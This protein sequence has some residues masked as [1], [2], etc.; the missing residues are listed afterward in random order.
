MNNYQQFPDNFLIGGAIAALQCEGAYNEG[1][2]GKATYDYYTNGMS[3]VFKPDYNFIEDASKNYRNRKGIDF[4]HRYKEDIALF[5]EMGFKCL[6][7][8]IAWPRIFPNGDDELPNEEGLVFYDNVIDELLKYN[9]EPLI[10]L[11]H[12]EIPI[13]LIEKYQGWTNRYLIQLFE[14]YCRVL[15]ERYK[16]KVK[17]WI[18]FNEINGIADPGTFRPG[19][20]STFAGCKTSEDMDE[21]MN[22]LFNAAHHQLIASAKVVKMCHEIMP[23]AK[24][25]GM[26]AMQ[27]SYAYT[28]NPIDVCFNMEE[29]ERHNYY[30]GDVLV[31]GAYGNYAKRVWKQANAK[32][33]ILDGDLQILKEGIVDYLAIS[34]YS[35]NVVAKANSLEET[36]GNLFASSVNPYLERSQWGWTK[37]SLGLYIACEEL[38]NRYQIPLFIV[39]NG[40]GAIDE[41]IIDENGN[42]IIHDP[43]RIDYIKDHLLEIMHAIDNGVKIMG[44]LEW[45][46]IDMVSGGTGEM[47]KRYGFIYV[48]L[49]DD[50]NGSMNRY[51]KDSFDWYK[52]VIATNGASLERKL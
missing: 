34:Y 44:Y 12:F 25:G 23:E 6:R 30:Y 21:S 48:D 14:K 3:S 26:I 24:I 16:G 5:A 33:N 11:N 20:Y 10:T 42:T 32:V 1:G 50:G 36:S 29:M 22:M 35:T 49:D 13:N 27:S 47:K 31:R 37:D 28:C 51:K 18:T 4:Y 9:I 2:K 19:G 38:Y 46:S 39:E 41:V 8:S 15:F 17:Y 52:Q 40:I 43:Y 7:L 45:G